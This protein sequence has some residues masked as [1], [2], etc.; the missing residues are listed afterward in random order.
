MR[1]ETFT[2]S[3][4][5][6]QRVSVVSFR[7]TRHPPAIGGKQQSSNFPER[8]WWGVAG[9]PSTEMSATLNL[10]MLHEIYSALFGAA[11]DTNTYMV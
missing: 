9:H 4:K 1:Q 3:Q 6:L 7:I 2:L 5:E 8:N 10:S 11:V